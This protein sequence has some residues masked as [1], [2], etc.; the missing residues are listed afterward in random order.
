MS[1]SR[2][3]RSR[4]LGRVRLFLLS[5]LACQSR[6]AITAQPVVTITGASATQMAAADSLILRFRSDLAGEAVVLAQTSAQSAASIVL[7]RASVS[8]T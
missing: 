7:T 4:G 5:L 2:V 6:T 1:E 3:E 8:A